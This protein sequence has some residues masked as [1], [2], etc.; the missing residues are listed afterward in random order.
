MDPRRIGVTSPFKKEKGGKKEKSPTQPAGVASTQ[1]D[2]CVWR[3]AAVATVFTLFFS[4]EGCNYRKLAEGSEL[5]PS[6]YLFPEVRKSWCIFRSQLSVAKARHGAPKTHSES[7]RV[8]LM[9]T[10][11]KTTSFI[12]VERRKDMG[13]TLKL[14]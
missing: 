10:T 11:G 4:A 2:L 7:T 13:K 6:V 5:G 12:F 9:Q 8:I 14:K 1:R 3:A